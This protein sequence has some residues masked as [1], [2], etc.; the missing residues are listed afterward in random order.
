[1]QV[2]L[3]AL[4]PVPV[5]KERGGPASVMLLVRLGQWLSTWGLQPAVPE[6]PQV[7]VLTLTLSSHALSAVWGSCCLAAPPS[8]SGNCC[9]RAGRSRPGWCCT[10]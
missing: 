2:G 3:S 10:G 5:V 1:M 7:L 9:W 6:L 8:A 4:S